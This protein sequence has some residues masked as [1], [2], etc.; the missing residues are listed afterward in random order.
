MTYKQAKIILAF[1]ENNM[2][3]KDTAEHLYFA[4]GTVHY[5]LRN[6]ATETGRDPK[7]F[8]DLCYLVGVAVQVLE[9]RKSLTFR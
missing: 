8:Y 5:H 2:R 9:G 4:E 3:T 6:I 1:A 7:K